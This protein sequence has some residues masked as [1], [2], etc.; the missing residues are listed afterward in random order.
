MCECLKIMC[1]ILVSYIIT[2]IIL[3]CLYGFEKKALSFANQISDI[4]PNYFLQ[5]VFIFIIIFSTILAF[6]FMY[7]NNKH[8]KKT[9]KNYI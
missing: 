5:F 6:I 4:I 1:I 8:S 3:I 2:I 9:K 7:D